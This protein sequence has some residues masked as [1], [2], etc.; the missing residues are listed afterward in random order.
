[1]TFPTFQQHFDVLRAS[2]EEESCW[3]WHGPE[4][5]WLQ[6]HNHMPARAAFLFGSGT[7][8][9][10]TPG[11]VLFRACETVGCVRPEHHDQVTRAE[12]SRRGW[13]RRRGGG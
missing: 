7:T 8:P 1:M 5:V 4:T 10:L 6:G 2:G 3:R 12:C 13:V 11:L 9:T